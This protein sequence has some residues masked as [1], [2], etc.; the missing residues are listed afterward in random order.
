MDW[1]TSVQE[2]FLNPCIEPR[3]GNAKYLKAMPPQRKAAVL[4]TSNRFRAHTLQFSV[5]LQDGPQQLFRASGF[6]DFDRL[7]S[8]FVRTN[9][10]N[11][12]EAILF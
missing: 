1:G 6:L 9:K 12:T 8:C 7:T 3:Q 10:K 5:I 4:Q 11:R 2:T